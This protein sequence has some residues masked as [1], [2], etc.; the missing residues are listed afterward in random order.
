MLRLPI[1]SVRMPSDSFFQCSDPFVVFLSAVYF[2]RMF[3]VS[4]LL[5]TVQFHPSMLGRHHTQ[6]R[7]PSPDRITLRLHSFSSCSDLLQYFF[8]STSLQVVLFH[9]LNFMSFTGSNRPSLV[10]IRAV[11]LW[12]SICRCEAVLLPLCPCSPIFCPFF[13]F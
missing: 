9:F 11:P 2:Q 6:T 3:F 13:T 10:A 4:L 12:I 1:R 5:V 8:S 7:L